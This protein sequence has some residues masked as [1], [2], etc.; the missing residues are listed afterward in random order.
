MCMCTCVCVYVT[1]C[2]CVCVCVCV[3]VRVFVYVLTH[4]F[5]FMQV[6]SSLALCFG[7]LQRM[8]TWCLSQ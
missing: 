1:V 2:V 3:Y 4:C 5:G 8:L 7:V 6:K